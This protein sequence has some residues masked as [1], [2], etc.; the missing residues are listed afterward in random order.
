MDREENR[1]T[2]EQSIQQSENKP[3]VSV[4][5]RDSNLASKESEEEASSGDD[6]QDNDMF[7]RST[8]EDDSG[9]ETDEQNSESDD[10]VEDPDEDEPGANTHFIAEKWKR[11]S[12]GRKVGCISCSTVLILLVALVTTVTAVFLHYYHLM[13]IEY[14][15]DIVIDENVTFSDSELSEIPD[16]EVNLES[17]DIFK[18]K[19]VLNILLIGTDERSEEFSTNARADSMMIL[20]LD[21]NTQTIRLVSLE[22]GMLVSIPG[23]KNDILTHTFRY[24]GSNLLME[25]VRTHLNV[26]VEKYVR[27][28]LS[29][30][31]KLID[32]VGGVDIEL[33]EKEANGLNKYPNGNTW[34][35]ERKVHKGINHFN[36]YEALQY[37]RLRWI[38]S[39][40]ERIKRQ[41][42]VIAAVKENMKD[43]SVNDLKD[44]SADCLPYIQTNLSALE[45]A[46]ILLNLPGY[47]DKDMEQMTIPQKGTYKTLGH[48]DYKMNSELLNQFL[49]R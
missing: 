17:T 45:I 24:G 1:I 8:E 48:V 33:T 22:R 49:Y 4:N 20:S 3:V 44:V 46:G 37:S 5:Y 6:L 21:N 39:D 7:C 9:E 16:G 12:T 32:E 11:L 34:K 10:S 36:G 25:T 14:S 43:L 38:D 40:F 18:D 15:T 13:Q 42:K 28:N 29:M 27:V 31:T 41:R 23:M 2:E 47:I 35:L 19:S 26:D 30:F